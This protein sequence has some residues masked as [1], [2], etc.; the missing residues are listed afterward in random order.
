MA[1]QE[2]FRQKGVR[3]RAQKD[4]RKQLGRGTALQEEFLQA[5]GVHRGL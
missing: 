3:A 5:A 4:L 1:L 2:E